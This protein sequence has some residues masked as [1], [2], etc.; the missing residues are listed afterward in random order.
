MTYTSL[1]TFASNHCNVSK[2]CITLDEGSYARVASFKCIYYF[3]EI[4][5]LDKPIPFIKLRTCREINGG[6]I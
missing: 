6:I 4:L 5:Y 1:N 3:T 2:Q